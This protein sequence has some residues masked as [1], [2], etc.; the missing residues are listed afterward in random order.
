MVDFVNAYVLPS[1]VHGR[2]FP[3]LLILNSQSIFACL[4]K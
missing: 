4:N 1:F 3:L 2:I